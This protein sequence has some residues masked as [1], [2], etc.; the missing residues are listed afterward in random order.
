M[1]NIFAQKTDNFF[2][3]DLADVNKSYIIRDC[4]LL[5]DIKT[6][7]AEMGL[8]PNTV[9]KILKKAPLGDPMEIE[10]RGYAL[11]IRKT[12]A[13]HFTVSEVTNE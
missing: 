13:E 9:V 8:V 5:P 10:V 4:K 3:L 12:E 1:S 11:C 6:R 2:S 7:L